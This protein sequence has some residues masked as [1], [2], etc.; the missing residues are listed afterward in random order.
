MSNVYSSNVVERYVQVKF[1]HRVLRNTRVTGYV[2]TDNQPQLCR[3]GN[4]SFAAVERISNGH[5]FNILHME[6]IAGE[7]KKGQYYTE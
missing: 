1:N 6:G 3:G 2:I 4:R 5:S 7:L